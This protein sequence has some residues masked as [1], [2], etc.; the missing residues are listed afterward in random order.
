MSLLTA[1]TLLSPKFRGPQFRSLRLAAF[2][3]TG[4]SAIA[5]IGHVWLAWGSNRLEKMG[6]PYYFLEGVLLFIGCYFWEVGVFLFLPESFYTLLI[7]A[8][9]NS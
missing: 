6:V 2:I 5:P 9:T 7:Y 1:I 8:E 4:L 3:G